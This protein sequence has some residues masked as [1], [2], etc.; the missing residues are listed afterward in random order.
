MWPNDHM[1]PGWVD[2]WAS[3]CSSYC[4]KWLAGCYWSWMTHNGLCFGSLYRVQT[5]S[6]RSKVVLH[7]CAEGSYRLTTMIKLAE[8]LQQDWNHRT[9]TGVQT[10]NHHF[11][12]LWC[13]RHSC[14]LKEWSYTD[15]MRTSL[16]TDWRTGTE[17]KSRRLYFCLSTFSS[18][19]CYFD[20]FTLLSVL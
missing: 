17:I 8:F 6:F 20:I 9:L 4:F 13:L 10:I 12:Q 14:S 5:S 18:H 3:S 7:T 19:L 1:T 15:D 16:Q 2:D 11:V